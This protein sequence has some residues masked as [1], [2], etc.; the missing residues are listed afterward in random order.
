[1]NRQLIPQ[2]ICKMEKRKCVVLISGI[3]NKH[4]I[5]EQTLISMYCETRRDEDEYKPFIFVN[6]N[7]TKSYKK[8]VR[9][10]FG[11]NIHRL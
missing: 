1:M 5:C 9:C 4:N 2:T 8:L 7:Y 10:N 11:M 6:N 3:I